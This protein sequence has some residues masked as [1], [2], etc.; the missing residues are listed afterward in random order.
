MI[1]L[2]RMLI[3][4]EFYQENVSNEILCTR[5][6]FLKNILSISIVNVVQSGDGS[7][8]PPPRS[9]AAKG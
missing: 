7:S 6:K 2:R 4:K 5:S 1:N 3:S 8:P 9:T